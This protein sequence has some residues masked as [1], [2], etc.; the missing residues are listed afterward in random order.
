M[1][2]SNDVIIEIGTSTEGGT[3]LRLTDNLNI[4]IFDLTYNQY[5]RL[6][7]GDVIPTVN[8]L[9]NDELD[10]RIPPASRRERI[11]KDLGSL[12]LTGTATSVIAYGVTKDVL[13]SGFLGT[14]FGVIGA[15][16]Y[17]GYQTTRSRKENQ[18][19][20]T[21]TDTLRKAFGLDY[22]ETEQQ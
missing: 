13:T 22:Y 4:E 5:N 15:S 20:L 11:M 16:V 1:T 17:D 8:E 2:K 3:A 14:Y 7:E 21:R 19:R 9:I 6:T 18:R 12:T 10:K